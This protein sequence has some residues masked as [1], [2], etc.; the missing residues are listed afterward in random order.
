MTR[1]GM[2]VDAIGTLATQLDGQAAA[3]LQV[4]ASVDGLVNK[5]QV[6]WRGVDAQQFTDWWR[7]KH[8]PTMQRVHDS[9]AGLAQSA[10][11][12]ATEQQR[13]SGVHAPSPAPGQSSGHRLTPPTTQPS[14]VYSSGDFVG[15]RNAFLND[16]KHVS[17]GRDGTP[18]DQWGFAFTDPSRPGTGDCTSFVAWR[19]NQLAQSHHLNWSFSNSA[20][21]GQP[22]PFPDGHLGNAS[23]WGSEAAAA[24]FTPDHVARVG[25]VA[26][27]SSGHVAI[28][29]Q[30]NA[31]GSIVIEESSYDSTAYDT[32]TV[33]PGHQGYPTAFIHFLPGS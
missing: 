25:A 1:L 8:R 4:M 32:R 28:V 23:D 17:T 7:G 14:P 22:H 6:E 29:R 10:K 13:A 26:W 24:G 3:I 5:S 15:D 20:V 16:W 2:N 30:V 31:D 33:W 21:S 27:Y 18:Y 9:I 19:L 11:N 12:N